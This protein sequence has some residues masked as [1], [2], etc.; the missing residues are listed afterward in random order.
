MSDPAPNPQH[1]SSPP[2]STSLPEHWQFV[3]PP[4]DGPNTRERR[5]NGRLPYSGTAAPLP[6]ELASRGPG[7]TEEKEQ[8][9]VEEWNTWDNTQ[10]GQQQY[11]YAAGPATGESDTFFAI[12]PSLDFDPSSLSGLPYTPI[13]PSTVLPGFSSFETATPS[14]PA[15]GERR[16]FS[17]SSVIDHGSPPPSPKLDS[18][19]APSVSLA[20][21]IGLTKEEWLRLGGFEADDSAA[22]PPLSSLALPAPQLEAQDVFSHSYAV[23]PSRSAHPSSQ[24]GFPPPSPAYHL[25]PPPAS[26]PPASTYVLPAQP[27]P[28]TRGSYLKLVPLP[29]RLPT[30][31]PLVPLQADGSLPPSRP[32]TRSNAR[33]APAASTPSCQRIAPY[34]TS[35]SLPPLERD[36]TP[37]SSGL[38]SYRDL[39][40]PVP[41][42][43]PAPA[44][45]SAS[46][47][48]STTPRKRKSHTR[49]LSA[50]HIPR[51]RNAFILFR[52]HAVATGL[53]PSSMGITDHKYISQIVG[54]VWRGLSAEERRK[55]DDLAAEEKRAHREKYP[56]YRFAP[57]QKGKRAAAGEGKKARARAAREEADRAR[58][59]AMRGVKSSSHASE[60]DGG[61]SSE[62]DD[63]GDADEAEYVPRPTRS[64]SKSAAASAASTAAEE[65]GLSEDDLREQRRMELIGQAMLE[66]IEEEDILVRVNEE[67]EAEDRALGKN[68]VKVEPLALPPAPAPPKRATRRSPAKATPRKTRS[69]VQR[70]QAS[71]SGDIL[72]NSLP[73]SP[74]ESSSTASPTRPSPYARPPQRG[75]L[76]S[77]PASSASP[78]P[79]RM[80]HPSVL[81]SATSPPSSGRHPLSRSHP[82]PPRDEAEDDLP[83]SRRAKKAGAYGGLG[84]APGTLVFP[85]TPFTDGG[86]SPNPTLYQTASPEPPFTSSSHAIEQ[87]LFAGATDSRNFSLGRWELRKPSTAAGSRREM[88]AQQEEEGVSTAGWLDRAAGGMASS[89]T[90]LPSFAIDPKEFLVESGLEGDGAD[91]LFSPPHAAAD[92]WDA[93][94]TLSGTTS[95]WASSSSVYSGY[96]PSLSSLAT[97]VSR[98]AAKGP[99][100]GPLF[101]PRPAARDPS[102]PS[103][104]LAGSGASAI[105]DPF[106]ASPFSSTFPSAAAQQQQPDLFHFGEVDLFAKPP[107]ALALG[108]RSGSG[109]STGT[110]RGGFGLGIRFDGEEGR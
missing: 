84:V 110:D 57:R 83:A 39:A 78:S 64:R 46:S 2:S 5:A 106:C 63:D 58:E 104:V 62:D 97:T 89:S 31:P 12:D 55:W 108:G 77:S 74:T 92:T 88:L 101:R 102:L 81:R 18:A 91:E 8:P 44:S 6:I 100:P 43:P 32:P 17:S 50:G 30:P 51:P 37:V 65:A 53:I 105:G 15:N 86:P 61:A 29:A 80:Q 22:L 40:L 28:S 67:L 87:P 60:W 36:L 16:L 24:S 95:A 75:A 54:S 76:P 48:T 7:G 14:H 21:G 103:A 68:E 49:R 41:P 59:D 47:T 13:D 90:R 94:S 23:E 52:S 82:A 99:T 93:Q 56:D 72:V 66:G 1:L 73:V 109:A 98:S 9:A 45:T 42:A 85:P 27:P 38:A 71:S 25:P 107:P 33:S 70:H 35:S 34:P 26:A 96:E 69:S 20:T 79:Q 11:W 10:D 3:P 19:P 4:T